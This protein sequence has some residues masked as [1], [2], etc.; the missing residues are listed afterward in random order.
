MGADKLV[1]MIRRHSSFH[2]VFLLAALLALAGCAGPPPKTEEKVTCPPQPQ[3]E[4]PR[5][6]LADQEISKLKDKNDDLQKT[7]T[8][9]TKQALELRL[10]LA[11]KQSRIQQLQLS[12]EQLIQEVVR[13]K[14]RLRSR[15]SKAETVANL[16][17]LKQELKA[18]ESG[19]VS[20]KQQTQLDRARHYLDMSENALEKNNYEGSS[21][22]MGQA[23]Q[24]LTQLAS[25]QSSKTFSDS[26]FPVPVPMKTTK[27][28]NLREG[29]NLK[30]RVLVQLKPGVDV[31]AIDRE[32]LW[33]KIRTP[34]G[35]TGWSHFSL[36]KAAY[37]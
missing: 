16:A 23:R 35:K 12:Q 33:V 36:L 6:A 20:S 31:L 5:L 8:A 26:A 2:A 10:Q 32:G 25:P 21:Y 28:C 34:D 22:L 11:E 7:V 3:E 37:H 29:A 14:A 19:E 13:A 27:L 4:D 15:N 18:A 17:E 30:S 9:Q 1:W 24:A